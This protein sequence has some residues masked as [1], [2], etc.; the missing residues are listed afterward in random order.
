MTQTDRLVLESIVG[1]AMILDELF[2]FGNVV[3]L[4]LLD[5]AAK[6]G[7]CTARGKVFVRLGVTDHVSFH[8]NRLVVGQ[9][10]VVLDANG[11]THN[12]EMG[13]FERVAVKH[14]L[15]SGAADR[16]VRATGHAG[17]HPNKPPW[18]IVPSNDTNSSE[19]ESDNSGHQGEDE[20]GESRRNLG[21]VVRNRVGVVT[22]GQ[23][24]HIGSFHGSSSSIHCL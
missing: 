21:L 16:K 1:H 6:P 23:T 11:A 20:Q 18:V 10:H 5:T 13:H 14:N 15:R 12:V 4:G 17:G 7:T 2:G 24:D 8:R 9:G 22:A 19:N 3:V